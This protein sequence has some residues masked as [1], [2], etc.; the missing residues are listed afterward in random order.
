MMEGL[1]EVLAVQGLDI[2]IEQANHRLT[3]LPEIDRRRECMESVASLERAIAELDRRSDEAA[4]ALAASER[5]AAEIETKVRRLEGQLKTVIAPREAE[6]LQHEIAT[7]NEARGECDERGLA[8]L[9]AAEQSDAER[10]KKEGELA[11]SR[12]ELETVLTEL[13][14]AQEVIQVEIGQLASRRSAT[15]SV[16]PAQLLAKYETRRKQSN[17]VAIAELIGAA[18]GGC[19]LDLSQAERDQLRRLLDDEIPECPHCGCMLVV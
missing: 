15:A 10:T 5:E 7:L 13:R 18:C 19:H 11:T 4:L 16:A 1:A 9:V 2:A 12:A 3:H 8:A 6:A 14:I 17:R